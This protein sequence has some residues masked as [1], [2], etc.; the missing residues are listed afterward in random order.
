MEVKGFE[1]DL[2]WPCLHK[3]LYHFGCLWV[4][5]LKATLASCPSWC[6]DEWQEKVTLLVINCCITKCPQTKWIKSTIITYFSW[7][8]FILRRAQLGNSRLEF[9]K[10]VVICSLGLTVIWKLEGLSGAGACTSKVTDSLSWQVGAGS[11]LGAL[12]PL[13]WA[14]WV[15]QGETCTA[16][17]TKPHKSYTIT[18]IIFY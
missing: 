15:I 7:C 14:A 12:A 11:G 13:H 10:V 17:L 18:I 2:H 4:G 9:C 16:L 3:C 6:H 5:L 1:A 8:F